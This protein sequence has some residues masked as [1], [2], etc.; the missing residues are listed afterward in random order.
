[1]TGARHAP[2]APRA[3]HAPH[4][5]RAPRSETAE[6]EREDASGRDRPPRWVNHTYRDYSHVSAEALPRRKSA[7]LNFP[8]KLHRILSTEEFAHII[9]WMPHGRAWKI[10]DKERLMSEVVPQFFVQRK[11]ESFTRQLNGWG[12]KRHQSGADFNAY[13]HECFLRGLPHLA[14]LLT[15]VKRGQGKQV[16]HVEG[17]P[18][19]YEMDRSH[20]LPR[21]PLRPPTRGTT[22]GYGVAPGPP[23]EEYGCPAQYAPRPGDYPP[24]EPAARCRA[25]RPRGTLP[26]ATRLRATHPISLTLPTTAHHRDI[27]RTLPARSAP[28]AFRR[29]TSPVSTRRKGTFQSSGDLRARSMPTVTEVS[30]GGNV[31]GGQHDIEGFGCQRVE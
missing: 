17:E 18:N 8:S 31:R 25:T 14:V 26:R 1:M 22:E 19:F 12:F 4:A 16:P 21:P 7:T 3:P 20:P 9:S 28:P 10:H 15:R 11:Y 30:K 6:P 23:P 13:Y 29:P 27:T 2:H 24:P 5:P